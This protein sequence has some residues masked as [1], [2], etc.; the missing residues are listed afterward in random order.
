M[1][2]QHLWNQR[3]NNIMDEIIK[4]AK[5][6]TRQIGKNESTEDTWQGAP[7]GLKRFYCIVHF[8][9]EMDKDTTSNFLRN[10]IIENEKQFTDKVRLKFN[11]ADVSHHLH[12]IACRALSSN[13]AR[14]YLNTAA[15]WLMAQSSRQQSNSNNMLSTT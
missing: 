13:N 4:I 9:S 15:A 14:R 12:V 11:I 8:A 2:I 7:E 1:E 10:H 6:I 3:V 5:H